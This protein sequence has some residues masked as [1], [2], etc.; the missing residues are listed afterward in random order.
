MKIELTC[1][2]GDTVTFSDSQ[3]SYINLGGYPDDLGRVFVIQVHADRWLEDHKK[4]CKLNGSNFGSKFT[5]KMAK[6]DTS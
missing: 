6:K 3:G 5:E 1:K 2:C 4:Y